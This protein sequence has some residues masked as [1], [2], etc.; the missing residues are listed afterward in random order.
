MTET[1]DRNLSWRAERINGEIKG[2]SDEP[3]YKGQD[4]K[5]NYAEV[6]SA[7]MYGR[8]GK[9]HEPKWRIG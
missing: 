6:A 8:I 2:I 3:E 1:L 9:E 4:T 7:I 5:L